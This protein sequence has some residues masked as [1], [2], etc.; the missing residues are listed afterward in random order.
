MPL[1]KKQSNGNGTVT[2]P[3]DTSNVAAPR[4]EAA[5]KEVEKTYYAR[6]TKSASLSKD[7]Y[8]TRKEER[9]IQ[10]DKDMAWSGL[11]QACVNSVGLVQLNTDN[12]L[13]GFVALVVKA[14]DLLLQARDK[15]NG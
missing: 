5:Q 7:E 3:V 13:E 8:W 15:R 12:T 10:R 4:V 11:A 6:H 14:T 1:M 9:D 2:T